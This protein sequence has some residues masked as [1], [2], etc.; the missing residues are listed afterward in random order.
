MF[1]C[2]YMEGL[3]VAF[4]VL[5]CSVSLTPFGTKKALY[6]NCSC[7]LL[8]CFLDLF[9]DEESFL[10]KLFLIT[11][12]T[13]MMQVLEKSNVWMNSSIEQGDPKSFA[14]KVGREIF[15]LQHLHYTLYNAFRIAGSS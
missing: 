2:K 12:L 5:C 13:P 7:S 15:G 11:I 6:M 10:Y 14:L 9:S 1:E 8:L 4:V 3:C